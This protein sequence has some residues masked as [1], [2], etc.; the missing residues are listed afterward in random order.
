[1]YNEN[2]QRDIQRIAQIAIVP[3]MLEVICETTNMGFAA[4]AR[5]T[6]ES[7]VA[8]SVRDTISFGLQPGGELK[9]ET[10]I[11]NEIRGS[12][13]P[14]V[15]NHVAENP[16]FCR[17]HTPEMY[18]FQSYI[19]VPIIRHNGEMFGTL[20]AI[21]PKPAMI[22]N[23]KT[24]GMFALFAQLIAFHLE[25]VEKLEQSNNAL[26]TLGREL[27]ET[28]DENR[29]YRFISNHNL[30]EP[31]RKLRVFSNILS[32]AA[33]KND[34]VKVSKF[35]RKINQNAQQFSMMIKDLAE[36]SNLNQ[37]EQS[38]ERV[39]LNKVIAD[40][41]L[42]VELEMKAKNATF[43]YDTLPTINGIT[44]QIEQLFYHLIA[45][46]LKFSRKDVTPVISINTETV[47]NPGEKH[48]SFV[49]GET[50]FVE[51]RVKDNGIGIQPTLLEKIFDIFSKLDYS[52]AISGGGV[53]LAYCRKI[54]RNHGGVI[55]A[56]SEPM[57]GTTFVIRLPLSRV[58]DDPLKLI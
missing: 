42:Q 10:T 20:C 17:H 41:Y 49:N 29:Q 18:G 14:V 54:V 5:V 32:V 37:M 30:Q 35:A 48:A 50:G 27:S 2:I 15:V 52:P 4:I 21:D 28:R 53:G 57:E 33:E 13:Q 25:S 19:S 11:C 22:D 46:A 16:H 51:I 47:A 9:L 23:P 7:W 38:Y 31:I 45:N 6:D 40:V 36:F 55:A 44:L 12:R 56:E 43:S 8:C 3:T 1:M 24:R 58:S 39:N 34:K 26:K